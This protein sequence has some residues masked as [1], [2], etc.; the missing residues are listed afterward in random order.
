MSSKFIGHIGLIISVQDKYQFYMQENLKRMGKEEK[1]YSL[2]FVIYKQ[3]LNK[4]QNKTN[5]KKKQIKIS[6]FQCF[7]KYIFKVVF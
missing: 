1:V 5:L 6:V 7:F 4:H 2:H 3:K